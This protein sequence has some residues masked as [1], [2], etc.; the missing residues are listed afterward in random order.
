MGSFDSH[1]KSTAYGIPV[2][3]IL[4]HNRISSGKTW[5]WVGHL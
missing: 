4:L 1:W 2:F 5:F 3:L